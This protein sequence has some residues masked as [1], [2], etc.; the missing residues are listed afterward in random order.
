[1]AQRLRYAELAPDG[2]AA[3]RQLE[4]YL[5]TGTELGAVLLELVRLR[6]SRING[7]TF[8]L[9]LH[10]AELLK[11]N[12][13]QSRIDAIAHWQTS[14]AFT[15]RERA[16]LAWTDSVTNVQAT[17]VPTSDFEAVNQFFA[18]KELADLTLAVSSI[19]AWNRLAI[20]FQ[21]EWKPGHPKNP[22]ESIPPPVHHGNAEI[23]AAG[24]DG[25]KV[26]ED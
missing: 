2:M 15:P 10:T 12:E 7:C 23:S 18:G 3:L 17:Q 13:P 9:N 19:N 8:C 6:A 16:A 20:A 26:A 5:N 1:M 25:G 11:H 4:H 22:V 14:D 21:A 24:D